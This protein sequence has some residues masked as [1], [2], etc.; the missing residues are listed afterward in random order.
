[1]TSHSKYRLLYSSNSMTSHLKSRYPLYP[2]NSLS[3]H[4]R[5]RY[6]LNPSNS[7][8]SHSR[9]GYPLYP[10]NSLS[11]HSRCGYPLY[12]SNSL[13]SHSRCRSTL[14][15]NLWPL[16][17]DIYLFVMVC[18]KIVTLNVNALLLCTSSDFRSSCFIRLH[19]H[20]F[21][22]IISV[23]YIHDNLSQG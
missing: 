7:L 22:N 9:C 14:P 2:S 3:F 13:S 23:L 8:S 10:S 18:Y 12:P 5:C 6:P 21:T 16:I 11:S 4:S 1:M 20:T 17:L 15:L 19:T